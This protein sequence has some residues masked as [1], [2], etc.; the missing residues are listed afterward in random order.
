MRLY[1]VMTLT[2]LALGCESPTAASDAAPSSATPAAAARASSPLADP[3]PAE[4][5]AR[6]WTP[7]GLDVQPRMQEFREQ[8]PLE[9]G[10]EPAT[11]AWQP[12]GRDIPAALTSPQSSQARSPGELLVDLVKSI[13]QAGWLG[14]DAWEQ[15]LRVL[16]EGDDLAIGVVLTWG[17]RDDAVAGSDLRATMQRR[18]GHWFI[19]KLEQRFHCARA[20]TD[21]LCA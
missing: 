13:D 5:K 8:L 15:T 10:F 9:L 21:N 12:F 3:Q 7:E 16:R 1:F 19:V 20:V 6:L 2:L 11:T 18:D 14:Q 17:L 4:A